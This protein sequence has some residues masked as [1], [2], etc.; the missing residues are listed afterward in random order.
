MMAYTVVDIA[1]EIYGGARGT[2]GEELELHR[3]GGDGRRGAGDAFFVF[4]L[5]FLGVV[6]RFYG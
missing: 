5:F 1:A 2:G 6:E 3:S 4:L